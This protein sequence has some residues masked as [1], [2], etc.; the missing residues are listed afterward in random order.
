MNSSTEYP[1]KQESLGFP[2]F[3]P[4]NYHFT[5]SPKMIAFM[6]YNYKDCFYKTSKQLQ[7]WRNSTL[8]ARRRY[9]WEK[10]CATLLKL[11]AA[12]TTLYL[13]Q[14]TRYLYKFFLEEN[15]AGLHWQFLLSDCSSITSV[16]CEK[17]IIT[18][19]KWLIYY[20]PLSLARS[21]PEP[22]QSV[23]TFTTPNNYLQAK[24]F[25]NYLW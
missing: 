13:K 16:L 23:L 9:S 11:T 12:L 17:R 14:Y 6:E 19:Q 25:P 21:F 2:F 8:T 15:I 3:S 1:Q 7:Q 24:P 5:A 20:Y 22:S 18:S 4:Q 10:L